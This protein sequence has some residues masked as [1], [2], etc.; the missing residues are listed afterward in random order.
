M[1]K[2]TKYGLL[3]LTYLKLEQLNLVSFRSGISALDF[4]F[5]ELLRKVY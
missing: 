5:F 3:K 2:H 4:G 1:L